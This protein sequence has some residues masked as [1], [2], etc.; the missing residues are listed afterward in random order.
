MGY[1]SS[2]GFKFQTDLRKPAIHMNFKGMT[3]G[4]RFRF[5][6]GLDK[7]RELVQCSSRF[8]LSVPEESRP[9]VSEFIVRA[10]YGVKIGRVEMDQETGNLFFRA[11]SFVVEEAD[12]DKIVRR[13]TGISVGFCDCFTPELMQCLYSGVIPRLTAPRKAAVPPKAQPHQ[14]QQDSASPPEP[15][16]TIQPP[17]GSETPDSLTYSKP[18]LDKNTNIITRNAPDHK[19]IPPPADPE[20]HP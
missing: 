1:F 9:A 14:D 7:E 16:G 20:A 11:S 8:P 17:D 2:R 6:I 10:N 5:S 4:M 18:V 19:K 3:Y 15:A 12:M 13:L